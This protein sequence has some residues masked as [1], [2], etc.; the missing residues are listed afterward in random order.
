MITHNTQLEKYLENELL[1]EKDRY[2]IRQIFSFVDEKKKQNILDNFDKILL[3]IGKIKSDLRNSQEILLWKAISNIE[4]AIRQA[5]NNGIK[6][7]T[8]QSINSL[9]Y[10]I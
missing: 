3:S 9:K 2:E 10:K 5:Q 1:T 4:N 8:I 6:N 7:A